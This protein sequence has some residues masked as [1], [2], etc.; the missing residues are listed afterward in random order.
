MTMQIRPPPPEETS[1]PGMKTDVL[2][3]TK[4]EVVLD[5]GNILLL[6]PTGS[7]KTLL[8]KT[9]AKCLDVPFAMCDCTT[10]TRAG[11]VGEDVESVIYKLLEVADFKI[12]KCQQGIVFLDEIDKI[13][14]YP[15]MGIPVQKDVGGEGVQ[16]SLL[17]MMEGTVVT[18]SDK[19]LRKARGETFTV[20]TANILFICSGAFTDLE[21]I[22][23][24][25]KD[26]KT[27]GFGDNSRYDDELES[28]GSSGHLTDGE[29]E[30]LKRDKLL[31]DIQA[32]D[33]IKYGMIPEFVGR[34][35]NIVALHS[36]TE[37]MMVKI[38]TEPKNALVA[39]YKLQFG[40]DSCQIEFTDEA[41]KAIAKQAMARRTGARGLKALMVNKYTY[42]KVISFL[43]VC[44]LHEIGKKWSYYC[45]LA[46]TNTVSV[47]VLP[48]TF[49]GNL[50]KKFLNAVN[51]LV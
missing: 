10:L 23:R 26:K 31:A 44:T 18:L 15:S 14:S 13:R 7:G 29:L 35:P 17:K 45:E 1:V 50:L 22:V 12:D 28:I 51:T 24:K 47:G 33:L 21:K 42:F 49:Y 48:A 25:R 6:G 34:L 40:M 8:A 2:E 11:Y 37:D 32:E 4:Q 9:L 38:L 5:K 36:L 16:Q 3:D 19:N 43:H 46:L 41:L 20:D 39:Q 30:D 27:L